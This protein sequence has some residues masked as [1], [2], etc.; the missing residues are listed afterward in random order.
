MSGWEDIRNDFTNPRAATA[1]TG[2]YH[3]VSNAT[4][5][6]PTQT[7]DAGFVDAGDNP[8]GT[9]VELAATAT[10]A[11]PGASVD[12]GQ[13]GNGLSVVPGDIAFVRA[14]VKVTSG[15]GALTVA[16]LCQW[17]DEADVG[18]T[19]ITIDRSLNVATGDVLYMQGF[20]EVVTGAAGFYGRVLVSQTAQANFTFRVTNVQEVVNPPGDMPAY[21]AGDVERCSWVGTAHASASRGVVPR[22]D[23]T[24]YGFNDAIHTRNPTLWAGWEPQASTELREAQR[25]YMTIA[26]FGVGRY[27]LAQPSENDP[28]DWTATPYDAVFSEL[29][30]R[31]MR[32]I[33]IAAPGP[34]WMRADESYTITAGST[35]FE[36]HDPDLYDEGAA[37]TAALVE[38]YG[39]LI[40]AIEVGNEINLGAVWDLMDPHAI[41]DGAV[42]ADI[43]NAIRT[44]VR[45]VRTDIPILCGASFNSVPT[46]V[47]AIGLYWQT[48]ETFLTAAYGAGMVAD[49]FAFH[50]YPGRIGSGFGSTPMHRGF[51]DS[52]R[53]L[54]KVMAANGDTGKPLYLTEF[55]CGI[56]RLMWDG[57]E[58]TEHQQAL[59][60]PLVRGMARATEAFS[61][62]CLHTLIQDP[63]ESEEG[64]FA[65]LE[66]D[67]YEPREAA[68]PLRLD[69]GFPAELLCVHEANRGQ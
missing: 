21:C 67:N 47:D 12:L 29:A 40:D 65:I 50:W 39:D 31:D 30:A 52:V 16:L 7:T 1:T 51:G 63:T 68:F 28:I 18:M 48:V 14:R 23:F 55:G 11:S 26:R 9:C 56:G 25:Q 19:P 54:Q 3:S 5:G 2:F 8:T 15:G 38:E 35:D 62:Y 22:F 4:S 60:L 34:W 64:A 10:A 59:I 61:A 32:A 42:Y 17:Y 20:H 33:I 57:S 43:H 69:P 24:D 44:A 58:A 37:I 36:H 49:G 46:D 27:D 6:G 53:A 13:V 66:W 45:A 41:P